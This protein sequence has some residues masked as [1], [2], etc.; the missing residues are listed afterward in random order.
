MQSNAE[1]RSV[2]TMRRVSPRSKTSRTFP[3]RIF[4]DAW[5]IDGHHAVHRETF[6][7]SW[8]TLSSISGSASMEERIRD[9]RDIPIVNLVGP[10]RELIQHHL[11]M[12]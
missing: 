3:L 1:M 8:M 7:S 2:A 11:E 6:S 10:R 12:L 9:I 4:A 5:E